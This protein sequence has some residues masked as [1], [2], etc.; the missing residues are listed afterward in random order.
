MTDISPLQK[1]PSLVLDD[2]SLEQR[3]QVLKE[4][5][6]LVPF[7]FKKPDGFSA[8]SATL[9][10]VFFPAQGQEPTELA[11][12]YAQAKQAIPVA[13]NVLPHQ[14]LLLAFFRMLE[15]PQALF[16]AL[17]EA[18][19]Q[20]YYREVLGLQERTAQAD[21]V[22]V[23]FILNQDTP[24]LLLTEGLLLDAGADAAGTP[25]QYRLEQTLLANP[26][27]LS[28]VRWYAFSAQSQARETRI[29]CD[30]SQAITWPEQGC[31]L[32]S[33]D[34]LPNQQQAPQLQVGRVVTS[35]VL[36]AQGSVRKITVTFE[37][38][39]GQ[40]ISAAVSKGQV[41][42]ELGEQ[43]ALDTSMTWVDTASEMNAAPNELDGFVD[44]T[45][46]FK[47]YSHADTA[48]IPKVQSISM[49]V[50]KANNVLFSTDEA[51]FDINNRIF[52][53]GSEPGVGMGCY[54]ITQDWFKQPS[55]SITLTPEW[56]DLPTT[57]F[58]D[59]Y[60]NYSDPPDN[61]DYFKVDITLV[62]NGV[63]IPLKK[64]VSLFKSSIEKT[65][66]VGDTLSFDLLNDTAI[67]S[68][69]TDELADKT[70]PREYPVW[71]EI[72]LKQDFLHK[73]YWKKLPTLQDQETLNLPY[74][75]QWKSL[76]IDYVLSDDTVKTQYLLTPFGH[77]S[78]DKPEDTSK[79]KAQ[80]YLGFNEIQPGQ[81]IHLHWQLQS[82]KALMPKWEYLQ[83]DST[84]AS[85]D[86]CV[87]DETQGLF[88]SS[89]W[90]AVLPDDASCTASAMP[91]GPYW[92]RA[93]I[94]EVNPLSKEEKAEWEAIRYSGSPYPYVFGIHTNSAT[95]RLENPADI[96]P[97]HFT[98]ALPAKTITQ[99][100]QAL[101]ALSEVLQ[102]WPSTGVRAA[103]TQAQF[104]ARVANYLS[105][106]QRAVSWR[107]VK[108]LLLDRFPEIYEVRVPE[109]SE[110][111]DGWDEQILT[112]IPRYGNA[113]NDD[114]L[115]PE[116]GSAHLARMLAYL[117]STSSP[118]LR[119]KLSN[120]SYR[121]VEV[122]YLVAF[123]AG[124][125]ADYG[126]REITHALNKHYMRWA[127]DPGSAVPLGYNLGY[128]EVLTFIQQQEYVDYVIS[129]TLDRTQQSIT[130]EANEV[131][132][133]EV[134]PET[135]P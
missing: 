25:L 94:D 29:I 69:W 125:N 36:A 6:Q 3:L 54:L 105:H 76:R 34:A 62:A 75:P 110:R 39:P 74:T 96:D 27:R 95:A 13:G 9:A 108:T 17:P 92:I 58:S 77:Q 40:A 22:V 97:S 41:W 45:P 31:R 57:S 103:E 14:A 60:Q 121:N 100:V 30:E 44:P 67:T 38:Q 80:L 87:R 106:R 114:V 42:Q 134:K 28:D 65:A 128:F 33:F 8:E 129:L 32:F 91:A 116:F 126:Y 50:E 107:D 71:I 11:R 93:V 47:L 135:K 55:V 19:K 61:N 53:F 115:R 113:D 124:F 104:T 52:P 112:L 122:T 79:N 133:L 83:Q 5:C 73:A 86:A 7:E 66:P 118:W 4:Y 10:D 117:Q 81:D 59:W 72:T 99:T 49:A 56:I 90:H 70:N 68:N 64:D 18:H 26:G 63:R 89:L 85:L 102:P 120:P 23:S 12:L 98:Q 109:R 131:L 111:V 43:T 15:T 119:V 78:A 37:R 16:N 1:K 35:K 20:L 48:F 84:W 88:E 21:R 2:R 127:W 82:P 46:L 51:S 24:E 123:K 132:V 130:C 101:D